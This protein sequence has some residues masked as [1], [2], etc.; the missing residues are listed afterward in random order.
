M[1]AAC[2]TQS[3]YHF[4]TFAPCGRANS[5]AAVPAF[6]LLRPSD[7]D[8]EAADSPRVNVLGTY[9]PAPRFQV[10]IIYDGENININERVVVEGFNKLPQHEF[11]DQFLLAP[12]KRLAAKV[13]RFK[14]REPKPW[15]TGQII[16]ECESPLDEGFLGGPVYRITDAGDIQV[17]GL[18]ARTRL[19]SSTSNAVNLIEATTVPIEVSGWIQREP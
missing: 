7:V 14:A 17:I 3:P 6:R 1:Q 2:P 12:L 15:S 9:A 19:P 5:V 10:Q 13:V 4:I 8:Q 11:P 16:L 18:V